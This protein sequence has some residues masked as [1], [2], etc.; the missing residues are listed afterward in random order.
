MP[1][2]HSME[3]WYNNVREAKLQLFYEDNS[4]RE[5]LGSFYDVVNPLLSYAN[6][7]VKNH[8]QNEE[9]ASIQSDVCR[10][11]IKLNYWLGIWCGMNFYGDNFKNPTMLGSLLLQL[12]WH[13]DKY[14]PML[15]DEASERLYLAWEAAALY[16][17]RYLLVLN[18]RF[19]IE[20][21]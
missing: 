12:Y 18:Q 3:R 2:M 1:S 5:W 21:V 10:V 6:T 7:Y 4:D 13:L 14:G 8:P 15:Y 17:H 11:I 19:Y 20:S 16:I 9:D